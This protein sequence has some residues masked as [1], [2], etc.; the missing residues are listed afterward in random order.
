MSRH[1]RGRGDVLRFRVIIDLFDL[2]GLVGG[3]S[4]GYTLIYGCYAASRVTL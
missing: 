4:Q 2:M 3:S 1:L